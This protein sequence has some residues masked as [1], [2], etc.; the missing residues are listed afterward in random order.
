MCSGG[1]VKSTEG[2]DAALAS[3][4]GFAGRRKHH[5]ALAKADH[6]ITIR[7]HEWRESTLHWYM[8]H[9]GEERALGLVRLHCVRGQLAQVLAV[10]LPLLLGPLQEASGECSVEGQSTM[11]G[12]HRP[13]AGVQG[14]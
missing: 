1:L 6:T 14:S 7:A 11:V 8:P 12:I 10:Q 2:H 5:H 3:A 9:D 4:R 13:L